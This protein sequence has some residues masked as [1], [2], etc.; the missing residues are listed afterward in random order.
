M[1]E[2]KQPNPAASSNGAIALLFRAG[3]LC[4]ALPQPHC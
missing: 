4:R 1:S 3:R 2:N